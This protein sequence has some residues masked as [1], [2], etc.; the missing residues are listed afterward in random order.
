MTAEPVRADDGR[1]QALG[2]RQEIPPGMIEIVGMLIVA[3]QHGVDLAD[4]IGAERRAGQLLQLDVR[5]FVGAGIIEG[6][7]GEQA[8]AVDF[9]EC[10]GAANERD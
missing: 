2:L 9:D 1:Q 5:Q 10:G 7:I 8:K 6:R 3:Q 4:R